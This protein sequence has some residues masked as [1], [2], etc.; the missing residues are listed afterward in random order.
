MRQWNPEKLE[1][2]NNDPD[3]T[4]YCPAFCICCM[5]VEGFFKKGLPDVLEICKHDIVSADKVFGDMEKDLNTMTKWIRWGSWFF[6]VLG[7]FLLFSP[8]IKLL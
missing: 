6:N 5:A 1:D 3:E 8:I 4:I 7:H 2:E